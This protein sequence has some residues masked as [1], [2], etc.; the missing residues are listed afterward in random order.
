MAHETYADSATA[1][2]RVTPKTSIKVAP[3]TCSIGAELVNVNL[4]DASRDDALFAEIRAL[5]LKYKVLVPGRPADYA[6][7]AC[8]VRA[9][10]RRA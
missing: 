2:R 7:R 10:L 4:G 3:L 5:L 6:R 9:A 1:V 8:G